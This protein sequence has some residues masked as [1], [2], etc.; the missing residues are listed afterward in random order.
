MNRGQHRTRKKNKLYCLPKIFC[1]IVNVTVGTGAGGGAPFHQSSGA[2]F[3]NTDVWLWILSSPFRDLT[4]WIQPFHA[5]D[6]LYAN[7]ACRLIF[8]ISNK[9]N[10]SKLFPKISLVKWRENLMWR[11]FVCSVLLAVLLYFSLFFMKHTQNSDIWNK[12]L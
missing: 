8:L 11:T 4:Y 9:E 10:M 3:W 5:F 6:N 1:I 7:S 2:H 12:C